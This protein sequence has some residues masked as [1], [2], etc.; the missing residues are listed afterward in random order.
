MA[1]VNHHHKWLYLMEPH[2]ASRCTRRALRKIG[3]TA[4]V[5]HQHIG[6]PELTSWRRTH[7]DPKQ[8]HGYAI[9]CTVRNPF[10]VLITRWK[11]G[12]FREGRFQEHVDAM[13]DNKSMDQPLLGLWKECNNFVYYEDLQEDLEWV[14][15]GHPIELERRPSETTEMKNKPWQEYY[16]GQDAIVT[17]LMSQYGMFLKKFGYQI[18]Y[19]GGHLELVDIDKDT[20]AVRTRPAHDVVV[21]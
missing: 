7:L 6:L 2:T 9:M 13:K 21:R 4:N 11:V 1:V 16:E 12:A 10:D 15:R 20:R 14:F 3:H 8:I 17:Y 19:Q 18:E 5:G